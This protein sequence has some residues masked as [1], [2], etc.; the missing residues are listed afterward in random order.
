MSFSRPEACAALTAPVDWSS[1]VATTSRRCLPGKRESV[2]VNGWIVPDVVAFVVTFVTLTPGHSDLTPASSPFSRSTTTLPAV[3]AFSESRPSTL[4]FHV[5]FAYVPSAIPS[6]FPAWKLFA[7]KKTVSHGGWW[8]S[9]ATTGAFGPAAQTRGAAFE[10]RWKV[11]IASTAC[12]L[13]GE[14]QSIALCEARCR[15]H[16]PG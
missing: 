9:I 7:P 2:S 16:Q 6:S 14:G 8:M 13:S 1:F 5:F 4:Q 10:S 3:G 11:R 12:K 15:A